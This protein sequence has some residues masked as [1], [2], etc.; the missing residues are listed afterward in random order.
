MMYI[1]YA[2]LPHSS[3]SLKPCVLLLFFHLGEKTILEKNSQRSL[4][5]NEVLDKKVKGKKDEERL[6]EGEREK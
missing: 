4:K 5:F 6:K 3:V 1:A 2:L